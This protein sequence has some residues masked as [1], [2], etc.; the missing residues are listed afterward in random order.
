MVGSYKDLKAWKLSMELALEIYHQTEGFPREERYGLTSQLRRA[1]VSV[2]S[3]IAEGKGRSSD[4]EL[5]LYLHHA[6]GS[7][8]EIET[9]LLNCAKSEIR[10]RT[11]GGKALVFGRELGQDPQCTDKVAET[12]G[13]LSKLRA[14]KRGVR[15]TD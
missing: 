11:R 9:Q 3:N 2:S 13:R 10:E 1:A 6:R 12:S 8:L 7:L 5:V 15:G 4:K 14:S